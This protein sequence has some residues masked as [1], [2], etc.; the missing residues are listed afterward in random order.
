MK[1]RFSALAATLVVL[2]LIFLTCLCPCREVSALKFEKYAVYYGPPKV[3]RLSKFDLVIIETQHYTS[4][5]IQLLK[6]YC[7]VVAYLSPVAIGG[8]E[9]WADEVDESWVIGY[10]PTWNEH[11]LNISDPSFQTFLLERVVPHYVSL[12]VDGLFIDNVD[13]A[14]YYGMSAGII[15][16]LKNL[17]LQFPNLLVIQNR[18]FEIV[19]Y[20]KEY[21][22]GF[23]FESFGSTWYSANGQI[24]YKIIKGSDYE[25]MIA[26]AN[27]LRRISMETG[28]IV[29]ALGYASP[30]SA[31]NDDPNILSYVYNLSWSYGFISY[32]STVY[33]DQV[34]LWNISFPCPGNWE[35]F[36]MLEDD[37]YEALIEEIELESLNIRGVGYLISENTLH[38]RSSYEA[39][40]TFPT[41]DL[42]WTYIV[43][44]NSRPG[45]IYSG[46]DYMAIVNM[47]KSKAK[48]Y[49]TDFSSNTV[50][51]QFEIDEKTLTLHIP[52][53]TLDIQGE[54][55]SLKWET[56]RIGANGLH[57]KIDDTSIYQIT[58]EK[59]HQPPPQQPEKPMESLP[60]Y[61][62]VFALASIAIAILL[63]ALVLRKRG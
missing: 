55:L 43:Y 15:Q 16:F 29:L 31:L 28:A 51:I 63:I 40:I 14:I 35:N 61:W 25:W 46:W 4:E 37:G 7:K 22:D 48:A 12:N 1:V 62:M 9:W 8:W 38:L 33:L 53:N 19:D 45:G 3:A 23:M 17:K 5:Q 20:T 6:G 58:V 41:S 50:E 2:S 24:R 60:I 44:I 49:L 18:G 13:L 39:E 10:D 21:V 54:Q 52:L 56:V 26:Q 32:V 27:K 57:Q 30:N 34:Y 42:A 36:N 59:Q 11:I 47:T